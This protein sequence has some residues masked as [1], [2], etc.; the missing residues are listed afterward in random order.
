[1]TLTTTEKLAAG[2]ANQDK[3]KSGTVT[4]ST[5]YSYDLENPSVETTEYAFGADANGAVTYTKKITEYSTTEKYYAH[6]KS[7]SMYALQIQNGNLSKP[8]GEVTANSFKGEYVQLFGWSETDK[9]YGAEGILAGMLD[10][11]TANAFGDYEDLSTPEGGF[12]FKVSKFVDLGY[13]QAIYVINVSFD[14]NNAAV[15]ASIRCEK[16]TNVSQDFEDENMWYINDGATPNQIVTIEIAQTEG[17][18]DLTN[19]YDI[20]TLYFESFDLEDSDGN[21]L[22][23]TLNI[24]AGSYKEFTLVNVVP[25]TAN[26]AIDEIKVTCST[27]DVSGDYSTYDNCLTIS[28]Y[29]DPGTYDVTIS[30]KNYTKNLTV[31]VKAP[32]PQGFD[33]TY[34]TPNRFNEYNSTNVN[35]AASEVVTYLGN[36]LYFAAYVTPMEAAQD[37]TVELASDNAA[38]V[39]FAE[40]NIKLYSHSTNLTKTYKISSEVEGT[41]TLKFKTPN[42]EVTRLLNVKFEQA[43]ALETLLA[44]RYVNASRGNIYADFKFHPSADNPAVGTVDLSG[45]EIE[46][47]T[48]N[49]SYDATTRDF[50][51]TYAD[52]TA[53]DMQ[54]YF[55]DNYELTMG[56]AVLKE[57]TPALLITNID[58]YVIEGDVMYTLQ[59]TSNKIYFYYESPDAFES[60]SFSYTVVEENGVWS[61]QLSEDGVAAFNAMPSFSDVNPNIVI[62]EDVK[63][64][65]LTCKINGEE[66]TIN[67]RK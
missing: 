28:C 24:E 40:E 49:Y 47:V 46:A 48:L 45:I 51:L 21:I 35:A 55:N 54:L 43:P 41:Y 15:S 42:E 66:T 31:N 32:D 62:S 14:V 36:T 27:Y 58:W 1:M 65:S 16:Y 9:L 10:L 26:P 38:D 60:C 12:K 25:E 34:Y 57:F 59:V 5:A 52:G 6:D 67:F 44:K 30:S 7:G 64:L 18:R 37:Y 22:G 17:E 39:T 11:A 19:P 13:Q 50:T 20:D 8:Y 23:D 2:L 61:L 56:R 53:Y 4:V 29:G 63:T 3:V 33:I